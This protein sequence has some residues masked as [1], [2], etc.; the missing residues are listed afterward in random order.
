ML[1]YGLDIVL[2]GQYRWIEPLNVERTDCYSEHNK[3][4]ERIAW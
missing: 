4:F 1:K 3:S 2:L